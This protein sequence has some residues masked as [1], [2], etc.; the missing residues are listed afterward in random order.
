MVT[1]VDDEVTQLVRSRRQN[2]ELNITIL[3]DGEEFLSAGAEFVQDL[4]PAAITIVQGLRQRYK[5]GELELEDLKPLAMQHLRTLFPYVDDDLLGIVV[6][7]AVFGTKLIA[8]E[9]WYRTQEEEEAR[10]EVSA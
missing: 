5:N 6:E 3:E 8:K 2:C 10:Q 4:S 7:G 9:L 1:K